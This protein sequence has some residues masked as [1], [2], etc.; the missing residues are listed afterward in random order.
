M[1]V[2]ALDEDYQTRM[3]GFEADCAD[4]KGDGYSCQSAGEFF[5]VVKTDHERAARI[6]QRNCDEG[7]YGSSCFSMARFHITGKG[8]EQDDAKAFAYFEKACKHGHAPGCYHA[9]L[10]KRSGVG[11]APNLPSAMK[12]FTV[13]CQDPGNIPEAC[14]EMATQFLKARDA[15]AEPKK[16][17]WLP[18]WL[19]GG[20]GDKPIE[21]DPVKALKLL[22]RGCERGHG[23]SC[24][25]AAVMYKKGDTG[26][27]PDPEKFARYK[28][29]TQRLVK[30][31]GSVGQGVRGT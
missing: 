9:G 29:E 11:T 28:A 23:P 7:N 22:E 6:F 18:G 4:G 1:E 10:L 21:R 27:A 17:G 3:A 16:G 8:A 19:G 15:V 13:A 31:H 25:N 5:A 20:G 30:V 24:F 2:K 14:Y 12:D 26:V